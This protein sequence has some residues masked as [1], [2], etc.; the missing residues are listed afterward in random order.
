MFEWNGQEESS[1]YAPLCDY[2]KSRGFTKPLIIEDGQS[3][4]KGVLFFH[5]LYSV[6]PNIGVVGD[7]WRKQGTSFVKRCVVQGRMDIAVLKNSCT[8]SRPSP[9]EM[10]FGIEAMCSDETRFCAKA[11][12][13]SLD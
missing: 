3:L 2:L 12:F 11:P 5:E 6:R 1:G 13:S 10:L 9:G 7:K 4:T 8:H